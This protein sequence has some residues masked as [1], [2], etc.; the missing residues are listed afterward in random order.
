VKLDKWIEEIGPRKLARI[1]SVEPSA[2]SHWRNG[3]AMPRP[4]KMIKIHKLSR[5]RVSYREMVLNFKGK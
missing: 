2:I 5:G 3:K 4:D 1:L